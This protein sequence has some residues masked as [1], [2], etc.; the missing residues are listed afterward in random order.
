M[1]RCPARRQVPDRLGRSQRVRGDHGVD[2]EVPSGAVHADD[3]GARPHLTGEMRL[4]V[5]GRSDQQP[6]GAPGSELHGQRTLPR[7]VLVETGREHHHAAR[8]GLVLHRALHRGREGV[9]DVF[10]QQRDRCR[11]AIRPA[12]DA[13]SGVGSE[14]ELVDREPDPVGERGRDARLLVHDP[15]D[16]LEAHP[17][18]GRDVAH[19]RPAPV[20]GRGV[21]LLHGAP[22]TRSGSV[23]PGVPRWSD[24]SDSV[25]KQSV[26]VSKS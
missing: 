5:T 14:I 7:R 16:G 24:N 20:G 8:D 25:V 2:G 11:P 23:A 22:S 26:F 18:A 17:G 13:G 12:E 9:C 15:G 19:R 10:E 1:R 4:V 6:V 21:L 3:R